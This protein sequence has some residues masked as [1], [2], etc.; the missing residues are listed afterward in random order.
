MTS[1]INVD[2]LPT[3]AATTTTTVAVAGVV[4]VASNSVQKSQQCNKIMLHPYFTTPNANTNVTATTAKFSQ[5]KRGEV[6]AK[7]NFI[8]Q[9]RFVFVYLH[10]Y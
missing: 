8:L 10:R 7:R 5:D 2:Y 3:A 1:L 9:V 4:V 6:L